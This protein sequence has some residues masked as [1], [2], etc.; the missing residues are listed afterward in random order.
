MPDWL[1]LVF[2][3]CGGILAVAGVAGL[4]R[5]KIVRP[6]KASYHEMVGLLRRLLMAAVAVETFGRRMEELAGAF[7]MFA[8]GIK[9]QV[10]SNTDRLN[11]LEE[12]R[13]LV[14]DLDAA[15]QRLRR[16]HP[17]DAHDQGC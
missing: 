13:E 15:V 4:I 14:V 6:L 12:M 11:R 1:T 16:I 7:S 5:G 9:E 17:H 3:I 2:E 10:A 8:V